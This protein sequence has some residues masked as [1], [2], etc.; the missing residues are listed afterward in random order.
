MIKQAALAAAFLSFVP[1]SAQNATEIASVQ[2]GQD[3]QGCNLFQA[4]LSYL[5]LPNID[6]SGSRLRQSNLSLST[7]NGADLSNS[8]LSISNLFG[9]RLTSADLSNANL[10]RAVMVG[11]YLGGVDFSGARLTRLNLSGAELET[12][13]G[14]SQRQLDTAC[15]DESTKLPANL[16]I[17]LCN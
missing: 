17:P 2:T 5:N 3:C 16:R 9:A 1:A 15:G 10:E 4:D 8:D 6:L 12:A 14:L 7:L 11:A 13:K